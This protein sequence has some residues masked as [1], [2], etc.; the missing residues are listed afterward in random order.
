VQTCADLSL[1]K[2]SSEPTKRGIQNDKQSA[3][4]MWIPPRL[5]SC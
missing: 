1:L 3:G 4:L 5:K 2:V